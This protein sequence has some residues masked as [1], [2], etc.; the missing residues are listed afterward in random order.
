MTVGAADNL[1]FSVYARAEAAEMVS[2]RTQAAQGRAGDMSF[3]LN[4]TMA[5][6]LLAHL[7]AWGRQDAERPLRATIPDSLL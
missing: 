6:L 2:S 3:L 4:W 7:L 5:S 1:T